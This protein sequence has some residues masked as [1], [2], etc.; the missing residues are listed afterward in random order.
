M[1][2]IQLPEQGHYE[3]ARDAALK[4]LRRGLDAERIAALGGRPQEESGAV[5]LPSLCWEIE[6]RTDPFVMRLLPEGGELSVVWQILVLNYLCAREPAPPSR[7]LSF[8][9]FA[10]GRGYLRAF[11]SRVCARLSNTVGRDRQ[12]FVRAAERL[13]ASP[14][15]GDPLR[16]IFRFFPLLEF[17]VVRYEADEDFPVSCNVLLADNLLSVVTMEDGIVAAE[18]LVSALEGKRPDS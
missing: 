17:L 7:F 11:E 9:D 18:R 14:V 2:Q 5:V 15:G 16:C 6:V 1:A 13:G 4:R 10:E 8:A 12:A 3:L